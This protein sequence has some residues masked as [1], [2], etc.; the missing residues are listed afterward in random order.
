MKVCNA[1]ANPDKMT[2]DVGKSCLATLPA[3]IDLMP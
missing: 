2:G 3:K 1:Q